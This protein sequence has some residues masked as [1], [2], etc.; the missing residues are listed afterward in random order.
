MDK[1][2]F[3]IMG[4]GRKTDFQSGRTFDLDKTYLNV[5]KPAVEKSGYQCIRGD[6]VQESGLID[7]SMYSLLIHSDLV[8]A[9]ITT[10]NPNAIYELGIRHAA[11]PH[12]TI[13]IKEEENTIPFDLSHNKIFHYTHMGD[14][15]SATEANRCIEDLSSIICAIKTSPDVDS[16]LFGFIRNITPYTLPEDEYISLIKEL[17][18]KEKHIFA[19][20]EHAKSEMKKDNFIEARKVWSKALKKVENEPF[21][22]QQLALCTY[23]SKEPSERTALN[24]ALQIIGALEPDG[25]TTNDPET[26]GITGAIYKRLWVLDNDIEYLNR[27]IEYYSKGF[28]VNDDYYTG[29]NYALCAE[30]KSKIEKNPDE[31]VYYK[32][33]AKKTRERIID[34]LNESL[35]DDDFSQRND[36]KWIYATL[37]NCNKALDRTEEYETFEA[38][39][40][41]KADAQWEKDTYFESIDKL[42]N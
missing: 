32:I 41:D 30:L 20:V 2:C 21:F 5:I 40:L 34:I 13:I 31:K 24:D 23:K 8:I 37:A 22:I 17:S 28:K 12:S 39:F 27:A 35:E 14:D 4:F 33:E 18:E 1:I 26:L 7:K 42:T 9:D 11:K 15:I 10:Y 38:L 19:L 29:E 25:K 36:I 6:E 3:V 16:P